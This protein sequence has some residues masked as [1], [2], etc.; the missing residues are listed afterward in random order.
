MREVTYDSDGNIISDVGIPVE[1]RKTVYTKKQ[2]LDKIPRA[3]RA[4]ISAA[5]D[6]GDAYAID[7]IFILNNFDEIDLN[8]L[9]EGFEDD[10]DGMVANENISLTQNQVNNF[11]ER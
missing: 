1:Q 10:L 5:K 11:L 9:P 3:I 4:Q 2:I 8:D 6:A 7:F